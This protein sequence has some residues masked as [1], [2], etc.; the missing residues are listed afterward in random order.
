MKFTTENQKPPATK[1][2]DLHEINIT[3]HHPKQLKYLKSFP[4]YKTV[5]NQ[6][7]GLLNHEYNDHLFGILGLKENKNRQMLFINLFNYGVSFNFDFND[8]DYD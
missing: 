1:N 7:C 2:D 5:D 6:W 4:L 3:L 8:Y